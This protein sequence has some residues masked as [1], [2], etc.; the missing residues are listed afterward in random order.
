M[1]RIL[2]IEDD[3]QIAHVLKR[4]LTYK[5]F[6]VTVATSGK[7][8]LENIR[9]SRQDL[10]VL[11]VM[12][13]DIDGFKIC[14]CLREMKGKTFPILMLTARDDVTDTIAGLESGADD[15]ITKP[16]DFEEVL[17]RVRAA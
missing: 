16:F 1:Q 10:V 4:A 12:L 2:V 9:T 17:A 15:Y 13:P 3:L 8:A 5:G 7:A 14:R 11:D 6:A